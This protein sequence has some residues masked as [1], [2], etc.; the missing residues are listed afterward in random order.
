MAGHNM[1][2]MSLQQMMAS[3]PN[4]ISRWHE[5]GAFHPTCRR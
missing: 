1:F 5:A 4:C 2:G 3:V